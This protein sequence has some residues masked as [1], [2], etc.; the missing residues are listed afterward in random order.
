MVRDRYWKGAEQFLTGRSAASRTVAAK[1]VLDRVNQRLPGGFDD[2][3]RDADRAPG[4]VAVARGHQNA[5][6]GRRPLRFVQ[7]ANLVVQEPH[8]LEVRIELLE[9]LPE[10]VVER[11]DGT[12]SRGGG[13][14][15]DPLHP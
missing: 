15:Q 1:L 4:L 2:V 5:R 12:V 8:G 10:R 6:L 11:V 7:D 3:I 9:S 13:V 14:L